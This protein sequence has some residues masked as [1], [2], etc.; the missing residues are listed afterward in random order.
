M[1]VGCQ[2]GQAGCGDRIC[3]GLP[4]NGPLVKNPLPGSA[5][6]PDIGIGR[7]GMAQIGRRNCGNCPFTA[8][9]SR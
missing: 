7:S 6:V 1:L 5:T 3:W 9:H 4:R 8:R 2:P